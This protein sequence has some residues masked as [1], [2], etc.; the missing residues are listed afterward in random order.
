M[1]E[2]ANTSNDGVRSFE[3]KE[4]RLADRE[5]LESS[6]AG[7]PEVDFVEVGSAGKKAVPF[8]VSVCYPGSHSGGLSA[9][10]FA[11]RTSRFS[12]VRLPLSCKSR[13]SRR[14]LQ[15][16]RVRIPNLDRNVQSMAEAH[17]HRPRRLHCRG[18]PRLSQEVKSVV[19]GW[20]RKHDSSPTGLSSRRDAPSVRTARP[21][22]ARCPR[23][24][25]GW[26]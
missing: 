20:D 13:G 25:P 9:V 15:P 5:G 7:P 17:Q 24:W 11:T 22:R 2:E 23:Y 26:A 21:E 16:P 18:G 1:N 4:E 3:S 14:I 12:P 8:E 19:I 6:T 10:L